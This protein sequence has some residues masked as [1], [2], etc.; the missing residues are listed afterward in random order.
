[1]NIYPSPQSPYLL[2]GI[3]TPLIVHLDQFNGTKC[4]KVLSGHRAVLEMA[5][6]VVL[7]LINDLGAISLLDQWRSKT[8][9]KSSIIDQN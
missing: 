2:Y 5:I 6:V 4:E 9:K 3:C 1:M 7:I 8:D